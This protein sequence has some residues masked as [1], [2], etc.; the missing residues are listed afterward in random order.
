MQRL[1]IILC[2]LFFVVVVLEA[3]SCDT[4]YQGGYPPGTY[5][6]MAYQDAIESGI[7]PGLFVKQIQVES[8][9]NPNAVS[10]AGAI[11]I[12]QF[13]PSTASGLGIDPYD[14]TQSLRGAAELMARYQSHYGDYQH[15]L[16]AYNCGSGCLEL[17]MQ[18]CGYYYWCLPRETERYIDM[19]MN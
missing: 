2:V 1:S 10:S 5:Q 12:A 7:P 16:A 8:G 3:S 15:G 13:L 11:G 4:A 6:S 14:P 9:F 18:Q 19:I 17:A